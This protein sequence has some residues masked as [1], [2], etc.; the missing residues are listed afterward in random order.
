MRSLPALRQTTADQ[1]P[2]DDRQ[3]RPRN[4]ASGGRESAFTGVV[5]G[6]IATA[7]M[8]VFRMPVS[9]SPP[10]TAWFWARFLDAGEPEDY[11]GRG[12]VLHALYGAFGGGVFGALAGPLLGGDEA[13]RERLGLLFGSLYGLLL[14]GFGSTVILGGLLDMDL[15]ADERLVF[16][17]S[18]L[19]YG[20]TLGTWFGA[21][22]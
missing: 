3:Q 6:L 22:G 14:S 7:V 8:T 1:P 13:H 20:I 9:M 11:T 18:H 4:R 5:A 10:P 19:V 21:N 12:L 15:D 17:V 16:H 2:A